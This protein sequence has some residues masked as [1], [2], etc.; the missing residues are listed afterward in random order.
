MLF[1]G[2]VV[3]LFF[4]HF[5]VSLFLF[6]LFSDRSMVQVYSN[7]PSTDSNNSFFVFLFMNLTN[8]MSDGSGCTNP[9]ADH[10]RVN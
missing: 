10:I 4:S 8:P 9:T 5:S 7:A 1:I 3:C 2:I 6:F